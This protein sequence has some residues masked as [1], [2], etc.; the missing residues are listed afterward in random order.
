MGAITITDIRNRIR[1]L[2]SESVDMSSKAIDSVTKSQPKQIL[3]YMERVISNNKSPNISI[4]MEMFDAL[5]EKGNLS[6]I[7]KAG[8]IIVNEV[9]NK[10][11]DAKQT[12]TLIKMRLTR[13]KNK[14]ALKIQQNISDGI[15]DSIKKAVSV[16]NSDIF[17]NA[18]VNNNQEKNNN[19]AVKKAVI[20][21]VYNKI[22]D[23]LSLC[24]Y[25]D[26]ILENYNRVSKRFNIDNLFAINTPIN[27]VQDTVVELCNMIDTYP[28][29]DSLKYNT[30]IET[31]WYGLNKFSIPYKA[32]DI[33][34]TTND[35]FLFKENGLDTCKKVLENTNLFNL[36]EMTDVEIFEKKEKKPESVKESNTIAD[37]IEE[38]CDNKYDFSIFESDNSTNSN[39]SSSN[40]DNDFDDIFKEYK[41]NELNKEGKP[42][43][44]LKQMINKLYSSNVSNITKGTPSFLNFVRSFFILGTMAI[45]AVGPIAAIG[46]LI[47]DRVI[48]MHMKKKD[49]QKMLE[50]LNNE[51]KKAQDKLN[52]T[53]DQE[54]KDKLKAYIKSI[55]RAK[56]KINEYLDTVSTEKEQE[57]RYSKEYASSSPD[58]DIDDNF[59]FDDYFKLENSLNILY[60]NINYIVE[61]NVSYS[62]LCKALSVS[63]PDIINQLSEFTKNINNPD[64]TK[65][66]TESCK[67]NYNKIKNDSIK[68]PLVEKS[69]RM[70]ALENAIE[71]NIK[72][73]NKNKNNILT[74]SESVDYT[75]IVRNEYSVI[76]TLNYLTEET[77]LEA[78]FINTLKAAGVRLKETIKKL[79][80]KEKSISQNIDSSLNNVTKSFEKS[81][82]TDN[83]ESV[84]KGGILP[85]ASKIIKLGILNAGLLAIGQPVIAVITTLGYL[86]VK[87]KYKAKERQMIIDE[88]EIEL[89]M[90]KKYIDI[91]ESKNDMKALKQLLTIQRNLQR[92]HQ[93]IKYKMKVESGD[94][95]H[96]INPDDIG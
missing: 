64:Y 23:K 86:G 45:P 49:A 50:C 18:P 30:I 90:C 48:S 89:E 12:Q 17:K 24:E 80:D 19:D 68:L 88:I 11:R 42:E 53:T 29:M 58:S 67:K 56:S 54:T 1:G 55:N 71:N 96:E 40:N 63:T 27:G 82:T 26:L 13:T 21:N 74:I 9:V 2:Q 41:K 77:I 3:N 10:V 5:S 62:E 38:Y 73:N 85:P 66:F 87:G 14:N 95:V 6:E 52:S 39:D 35:Y 4:C 75:D 69:S 79:S 60:D 93:R 51:I 20:E 28:I 84:L 31:A 32:S 8:N 43:S 46:G 70:I 72:I 65:I 61:N 22:I 7:N 78:S 16:T 94:K 36:D 25:C 76:Q 33:I 59:D 37:N 15:N 81:L 47:A 57:D 34:N 83:R 92:Q 44:K 91:A